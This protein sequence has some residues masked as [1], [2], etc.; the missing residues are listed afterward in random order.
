MDVHGENVTAT[1]SEAGTVDEF[2][3]AVLPRYM[4]ATERE[5]V[6]MCPH[7]GEDVVVVNG[8]TSV[9]LEGHIIQHPCPGS[10]QNARCAESDGRPLWN[11]KPNLRYYR[12]QEATDG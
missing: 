5:A 4:T 8:L 7:C 12:R 1:E 2:V 11:G 3:E 6:G 9:H 10:E